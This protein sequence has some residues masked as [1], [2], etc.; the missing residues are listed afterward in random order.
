MRHM[1]LYLSLRAPGNLPS[2]AQTVVACL[3]TPSLL[4]A[5]F[6]VMSMVFTSNR[7]VAV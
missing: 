6:A 1:P 3:V 2:C 5:L 7:T 4:A